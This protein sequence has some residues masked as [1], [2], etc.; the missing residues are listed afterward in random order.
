MEISLDD[1]KDN[2]TKTIIASEASSQNMRF[3]QMKLSTYKPNAT[4]KLFKVVKIMFS[5]EPRMEIELHDSMN[6]DFELK[7]SCSIDELPETD[8]ETVAYF[9]SIYNNKNKDGT[10]IVFCLNREQSHV[11][12]RK[13]L[14]KEQ[15]VQDLKLYIGVHKLS[16]TE[17]QVIG[18]VDQKLPEATHINHY[19][20][21]MKSKLSAAAPKFAIKWIYPKTTSGFD[22]SV[23]TDVL[24][25]RA[26]KSEATEAD[27]MMKKLLPP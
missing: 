15:Q 12:W 27:T 9:P 2:E 18:F 7:L 22:V 5:K 26:C 13:T 17:T 21:L 14:Q 16:L 23:K 11:D 6:K 8:E 19:K 3:Y 25:I 4:S 24:G 20:E 1:N 10:V